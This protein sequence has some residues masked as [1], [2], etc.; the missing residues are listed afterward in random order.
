[1]FYQHQTIYRLIKYSDF[2]LKNMCPETLKPKSK[3]D[4]L[5]ILGKIAV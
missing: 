5:L 4:L 1:M 2:L 3:R